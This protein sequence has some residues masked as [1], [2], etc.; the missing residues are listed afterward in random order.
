MDM[1]IIMKFNKNILRKNPTKK[2][3]DSWDSKETILDLA[4]FFHKKFPD[5]SKKE[6]AEQIKDSTNTNGRWSDWG[7]SISVTVDGEEFNL[8]SDF[9]EFHDIAIKYV[10][11]MLENEPELFNTDFLQSHLSMS[12]T[13][14]RLTAGDE[15]EAYTGDLSDDEVKDNYE[16]EYNEALWLEEPDEE[17]GTEGEPDFDKMREQLYDNHYDHVYSQLE[18]NAIGYFEDMGYSMEDIM[19][20]GLFS[21]DTE[22][23]ADEAVRTDGEAH[24]LSHYDG[25][26]EETDNGIIIMR[27]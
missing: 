16:R 24:F 14:K 23:A 13:D 8:V 10:T 26:Y 9:D 21:V 15:A 3:F 25:N 11:D 5:L 6:I 19:K 18:D 7:E 17:E 4:K 20:N 12:D 2:S 27:E 22:E 1:E